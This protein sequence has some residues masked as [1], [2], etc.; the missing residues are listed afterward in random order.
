[1]REIKMVFGL[2]LNVLR[3]VSWLVGTV[4]L[5]GKTGVRSAV[6]LFRWRRITAEVLLCP[7]G[8]TVAVYGLWDC[9]C[10]SRTE[11]WAFTSC[12]ICHETA[13]YVPCGTCG[14]PVRNPILP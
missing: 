14:L 3:V 1:V 13:A 2:L 6:L 9:A 10:G 12:V 11:G 8:H 4:W 5:G 7:R